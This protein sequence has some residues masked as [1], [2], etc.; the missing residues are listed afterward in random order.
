[1]TTSQPSITST[2]RIALIDVLR[3]V[4]LVAMTIYHFT[5][6]LEF[7]RWILPLTIEQP[8]WVFFARSI[9]SSFI[10]L[11]GFSLVLAHGN[12]IRWRGFWIRF[13]QVVL[14][15]A[16][17]SVATYF[18]FPNGFIFFGIL[19]AIALFSL[20]GLLFVALPWWVCVLAAAA[21][22]G[23][24][25]TMSAEVFA[26]PALIW[27]GLAPQDPPSNDY[28]PLFPWFAATLFGMAAAK[29]AGQFGLLTR[30]SAVT[31]PNPVQKPLSFIGRHSLIYY[32]VHQ[33]I[34]LGM[35]WSLTQVAGPPDQT[36]AA[37]NRC[38]VQCSERNGEQFCRSYC[39]C[40]VQGMKTLKIFQPFL[41]GEINLAENKPFTRMRS[42]CNAVQDNPVKITPKKPKE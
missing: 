37:I 13:A 8:G 34:L 17:I 5:W 22:L 26:H 21:M 20:L 6:D 19:H 28:V 18:L 12:G 29:L 38:V 40:V 15:A 3:G 10:F 24:E 25:Y 23:V 32:L 4:A 36:H 7:F 14:A 16:A 1:M 9:A 39:G 11:A 35:L 2:N 42:R 31:L 41:D 30:L 27:T 33:P